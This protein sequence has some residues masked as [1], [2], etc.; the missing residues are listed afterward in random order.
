MRK[1]KHH[2][3]PKSL[4]GKRNRDN[5]VKA[6]R[7]KHQAFHFLFSIDGRA[8]TSDEIANELNNVWCDPRVKFVVMRR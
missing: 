7:N 8:M 6:P 1:D 3:L 5:L 4:G 2:R